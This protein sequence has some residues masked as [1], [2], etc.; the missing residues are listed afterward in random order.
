M[1]GHAFA[2]CLGPD[3]GRI[4]PVENPWENVMKHPNIRFRWWIRGEFMEI[5]GGGY[6]FAKFDIMIGDDY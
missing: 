4:F 1:A 2:D 6:D 3:P 5:K